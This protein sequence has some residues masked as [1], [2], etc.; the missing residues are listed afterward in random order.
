MAPVAEPAAMCDEVAGL[1]ADQI[2]VERGA[3]L[4][5]AARAAQIPTLLR[6]IGRLREVTFRAVGEGTGNEVDLDRFD[7]TYTHLFAW[8]RA[9]LRLVGAYRLA[10]TDELLCRFGPEGLYTHTLSAATRSCA[11]RCNRA[12]PFAARPCRARC[13]MRSRRPRR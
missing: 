11:P 5:A 10:A 1:P 3:L 8:D 4:V 13:A 6:E 7:L 9:A 2:L 12:H